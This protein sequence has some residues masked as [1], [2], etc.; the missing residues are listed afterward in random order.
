MIWSVS[1]AFDFLSRAD[2]DVGCDRLRGVGE[3]GLQGGGPSQQVNWL[4]MNEY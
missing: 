1:E 3:R 4:T 2:G